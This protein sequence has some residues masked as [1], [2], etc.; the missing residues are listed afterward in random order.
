MDFRIG[1]KDLQRHGSIDIAGE[2]NRGMIES[3]WGLWMSSKPKWMSSKP[4]SF[5]RFDCSHAGAFV[6]FRTNRLYVNE[7]YITQLKIHRQEMSTVDKKADACTSF[8]A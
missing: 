2:K 8:W 6:D 7:H 1:F 4:G 3:T 5:D